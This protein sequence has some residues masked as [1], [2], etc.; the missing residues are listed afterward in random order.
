M[1]LLFI[2]MHVHLLKA[3]VCAGYRDPQ[4]RNLRIYPVL[5]LSQM[6]P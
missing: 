6:H 3:R 5:P 4:V 2:E 1:A